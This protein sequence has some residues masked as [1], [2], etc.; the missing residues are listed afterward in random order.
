MGDHDF[1]DRTEVRERPSGL[2]RRLVSAVL[3]RAN[4]EELLIG[5]G[6]ALGF[7]LSLFV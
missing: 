3:S 6:I 2:T 4:H 7:V 1:F 5:A